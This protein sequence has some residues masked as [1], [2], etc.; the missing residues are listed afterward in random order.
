MRDSVKIAILGGAVG[1]VSLLFFIRS[2]QLLMIGDYRNG[3]IG[4]VD[5][6]L[7]SGVSFILFFI[8]FLGR[9]DVQNADA[10]KIKKKKNGA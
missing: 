4:L 2:F 8:L 3:I 9:K 10:D 1:I 5:G 7:S 6:I